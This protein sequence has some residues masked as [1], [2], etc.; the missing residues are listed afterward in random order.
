MRPILVSAKEAARLLGI[1]RTTLYEL[2]A[3]GSIT[4]V[5]IRRCVRFTLGELERFVDSIDPVE[6]DARPQP[7]PSKATA[8]RRSPRRATSR[9]VT[10]RLFD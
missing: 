10:P 8:R 2:M 1:G 9:D 5:R 6:T 4:P 3:D 7:K